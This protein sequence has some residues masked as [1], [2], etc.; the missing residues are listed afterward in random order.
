MADI[1]KIKL[2]NG[3]EYDFKDAEARSGIGNAKLFYGTCETAAAT[4]EKAVV[5][6]AFTSSDLVA[7]TIIT[8]L[9]SATNSAAIGS[10]TLNVNSTGAKSIKYIY[11]S[12]ISNI[13]SVSY[14]RAGQAYQFYYDG[15]YWVVLMMYNT[16]TLPTHLYHYNNIKAKTAITAESLICGDESGYQKVAGGVTFDISYPL[17]WCTTA[18]AANTSDYSH[19][20]LCHYDRNIATGVKTGYTSTA[21][22]VQY[23]ITTISGKTAT[24]DS[25]IVTDTLPTTDDGKVYIV[26]GKL[27]NQSTGTNYFL[28]YPEHPMLWYK[29]GDIRPYGSYGNATTSAYGITKLNTATNSTSTTEAATPS[30]VK[31]A[32]DL[33]NDANGTANTTLSGLNGSYIYDHTFSISNGI[34]TFTPHVYLKGEEVT[35]NYAISCFVWKYR[36]ITG[37]E[38]TLTTKSDRGCDVTISNYGY[39]GHV[40]GA[41]TPPSS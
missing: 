34:A 28:L 38:V 26:L 5:C 17:V 23:L 32:Y 9:F 35:S 31:A 24:I 40:V 13:P 19:M 30:A 16:N 41:F 11:N 37:S 15:T 21:N 18:V 4:T 2:P 10:L 39:G 29:N 27:G 22:K 14:I 7:G 1:S 20:F 6:S 3:S 25:S 36:T 33:A 8:V 12:S